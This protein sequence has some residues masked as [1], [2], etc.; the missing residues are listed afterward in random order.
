MYLEVWVLKIRKLGLRINMEP[1]MH[2]IHNV[3]VNETTWG[4][5]E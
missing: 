3:E 1:S 2:G 4:K 5:E